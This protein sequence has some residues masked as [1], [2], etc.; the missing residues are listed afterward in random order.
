[1]YC[2]KTRVRSQSLIEIDV[3]VQKSMTLSD[4]ERQSYID[5]SQIADWGFKPCL[6]WYSDWWSI[7]VGV[8]G[9][10]DILPL[11][12]KALLHEFNSCKAAGTCEIK[13]K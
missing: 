3:L 13:W 5:L 6:A 4:L 1:M 7:S 12:L 8:L 10:S 2:D 9:L 11:S